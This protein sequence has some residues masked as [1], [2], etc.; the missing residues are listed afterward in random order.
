[1]NVHVQKWPHFLTQLKTF[2]STVGTYFSSE[3][4]ALGTTYNAQSQNGGLKS[5]FKIF[6][7]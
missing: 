4:S 5:Q 7:R 2:D 3:S 6:H 1:M